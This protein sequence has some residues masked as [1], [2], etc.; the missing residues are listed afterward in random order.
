MAEFE[1]STSSFDAFEQGFLAETARLCTIGKGSIG[2]KAHGLAEIRKVLR[3][4]LD[5]AKY[6][7]IKID[8]PPLAVVCTDV[9]DVFMAQNDLYDVAYSDLPDDQIAHAFQKAELPFEV[10]GDLRKLIT[11]MHSP[12]AVRSS[13]RLEDTKF[14]PFAGVYAT[15]MI[16]NKEFDP[17]T[18]FRQ[19]VEAIKFVYAS[20]YLK[21]AKDYCKVVGNR[22]QEEKMAVILQ[23]MVGKRYHDR[24]YPELSG[25]A[26]SYNYYPIGPAKPEDKIVNLAL[27]LGKVIV[28]GGISWPYSPAY[29]KVEPPFGSIKELLKGSQT[30]FWAVNMGRPVEYDPIRETEYLLE[31]NLLAAEQDGVLRYLASTYNPQSGRLTPGIGNPGPRALTFAPLLVLKELPLNELIN[32]LLRICE[33]AYGGAVEIEFAM[34]L[35]PHELGFLQ[36]RSMAVP[37]KEVEIMEAEFEGDEV[38]LASDTAFGNG[39]LNTIEDIV[40][41][42]PDNFEL[43]HT[44]AVVAE[45]VKFNDALL[46]SNRPYLLIVF[47]RL[48][49]A[50]PWLGIPVK[51]GQISGAKVIVEATKENIKVELSQGSHFFHNIINLN[52]KYF[53]IPYSSPYQIDWE[54]LRQQ[55]LID[56]SRFVC[57]VRLKEPLRVIVNGQSSKG[58]IYKHV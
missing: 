56:E 36:V 44:R 1:G 14:K 23:R 34:T 46:A 51:F 16:P 58:V 21:T 33:L 52:I 29:P 19:L 11:E 6:P 10:L 48:G 15:K 30:M 5:P 22:I 2:G 26:R 27:G 54:W 7:G 13:S 25:V 24:F 41:I 42:K 17:D 4:E 39:V 12:L 49:T 47:G 57:H 8:I 40:F 55:E 50:D 9:F 53:T 32:D 18:R 31:E 38:F 37:E 3:S 20:T 35:N 43:R 28:D 45:L